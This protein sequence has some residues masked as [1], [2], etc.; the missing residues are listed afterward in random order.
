MWAGP[1]GHTTPWLASSF[2]RSAACD[3]ALKPLSVTIRWLA[4]G[5]RAAPFCLTAYATQHSGWNQ[6]V[7]MPGRR[8]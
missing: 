5:D 7:A 2:A 4:T 3:E 1:R 6:Q 8:P